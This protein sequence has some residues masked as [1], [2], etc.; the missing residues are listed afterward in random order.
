MAPIPHLRLT[1]LRRR[2][3]GDE[4][5]ALAALALSASLA[6]G[7]MPSHI[8]A[9][10]ANDQT[11]QDAGFGADAGEDAGIEDAGFQPPMPPPQDAGQS[12]E[13]AGELVPPMPPPRDAGVSPR[14]TG[15][16]LP[17]MPPPRDSGVSPR[18]SGEELPPMPPPQDAGRERPPEL[19]RDGG[20]EP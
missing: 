8:P 7:D 11:V 20:I 3:G 13:D 19:Q 4:R 6:C 14:D 9:P 10:D 5:H 15:E 18:D 17:P 12:P 2:M 1:Y 16:V